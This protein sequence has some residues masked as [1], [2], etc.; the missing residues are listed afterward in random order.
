MFNRIIIAGSGG[1]GIQFDGQLLARAAVQQNLVATYVP[2]YGAERRGGPSF[3]YVVVANKE[4]YTPIFK[5]PDILIAFDQRARNTYGALIRENGKILVNSDLA[6]QPAENESSEVISIPASSI[7]N[8]IYPEN[9][10]LN[11]VMLG[12]FLAI[13]PGVHMEPIREIL[14]HRFANKQERL[15]V[16]LVALQKGTESVAGK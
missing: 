5:H 2:T 3:C 15:Q 7:A 6:S 8:K 11:L 4:V 10:P 16:N 9:G 1:Q 14:Q 13:V 12:A